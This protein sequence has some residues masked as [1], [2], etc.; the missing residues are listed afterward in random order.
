MTNQPTNNHLLL[1]VRNLD[2]IETIRFNNE[3]REYRNIV[4]IPANLIK[5]NI[6]FL[7]EH[8]KEY[9]NVY[10]I[11]KSG[12]R[13]TKV[14]EKYFMANENVFINSAHFNSLEESKTIRSP[15]I[16]LSIT[17]KIQIISGSI[18]LF[19]FSLLFFFQN[20]KYM[21]LVFGLVMVYVGVSGNCFMSPLLQGNDI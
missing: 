9:D 1:D 18:I 14:K 10:I 5:H 2:E 21:F 11:C 16:H 3:N 20:V 17:R 12:A 13:S 4:Y 19:L 8:F 15:D 6:D 7:R